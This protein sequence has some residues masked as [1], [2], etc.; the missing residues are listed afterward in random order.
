MSASRSGGVREE[1]A[2]KSLTYH[3][4]LHHIKSRH[5]I[6]VDICLHTHT[7]MFENRF[8]RVQ[9]TGIKHTAK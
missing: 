5:A 3:F 6:S 8:P 4:S 7:G 9:K 2:G 1:S